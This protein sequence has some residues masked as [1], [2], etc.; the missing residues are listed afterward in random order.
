MRGLVD[1]L[2]TPHPI[3]E[4]LPALYRD[5]DLAQRLVSAMDAALAPIFASLDGFDAYL[6][7]AYAPEDFLEW[8]S[9]WVGAT[10]DHT[11]PLERRR[12]MVASAVD[13]FRLRGTASGLASQ[14]AIYTG[15]QVEIIES[16]AAGWSSLPN[17]AIPGDSTPSL[18][19][20]V[21]VRDSKALS[22]ARLDALVAA[23]KPAHIPHAVEVVEG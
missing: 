16:G 4:T 6:D 3:G 1:G 9:G 20:R 10:L 13:L 8:L 14:V 23:A 2:E 15:G 19:V 11:W 18:V 17:A 22:A 12:M 21:T 7:P 5:D